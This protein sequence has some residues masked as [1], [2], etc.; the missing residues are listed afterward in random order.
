MPRKVRADSSI[1]A[2]VF[3]ARPPGQEAVKTRR[4]TSKP[5]R[6]KTPWSDRET[7]QWGESPE[8][9]KRNIALGRLCGMTDPFRYQDPRVVAETRA[10]ELDHLIA[11]IEVSGPIEGYVW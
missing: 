9:L 8:K 6:V 7:V 5:Y 1:Q 2:K 10:E 11:W 3:P 4:D